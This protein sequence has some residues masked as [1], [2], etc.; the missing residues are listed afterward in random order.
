LADILLKDSRDKEDGEVEKAWGKVIR[1]KR[2]YFFQHI[3]LQVGQK[4]SV[5]KLY[6]TEQEQQDGLF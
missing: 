5:Y 2:R 4:D 6:R 1:R 3:K